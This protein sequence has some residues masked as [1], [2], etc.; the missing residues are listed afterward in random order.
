[1]T[2]LIGARVCITTHDTD[3]VAHRIEGELVALEAQSSPPQGPGQPRHWGCLVRMQAADSSPALVHP[4][5]V[6]DLEFL[7]DPELD[8]LLAAAA[9]AA[10]QKRAHDLDNECARLTVV[11]KKAESAL[12]DALRERDG[13]STRLDRMSSEAE[14][15]AVER[16]ALLAEVAALRAAPSPRKKT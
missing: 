8:E 1:M 14:G 2:N 9:A 13:L 15:L 12:A 10:T 5:N 3:G 7:P 4:F 16:D 6:V 11:V